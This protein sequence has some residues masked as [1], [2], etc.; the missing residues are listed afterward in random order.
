MAD[1]TNTN[2]D[3]FAEAIAAQGREPGQAGMPKPADIIAFE[4]GQTKPPPTQEPTP[5]PEK[6]QQ[7]G[8]IELPD[9]KVLDALAAKAD[10]GETLTDEEQIILATVAQ[11]NGSPAPTPTAE[12]DTDLAART[13]NIGGKTLTG[14]EVWE[15]ARERYNIGDLKIGPAGRAKMID[16]YIKSQNRTEFSRTLQQKSEKLAHQATAQTI[17]RLRLEQQAAQIKSQRETLARREEE[18][19]ARVAIK[20]SKDDLIDP[21]TGGID[22]DKLVQY[23]ESK[24]AQEDIIR[25]D[26]SKRGLDEQEKENRARMVQNTVNAFIEEHP[27]YRTEGDV[28]ETWVKFTEGKPISQDDELKVLE[29][30]NLLTESM[31][32]GISPE[33]IFALKK[34][35]RTLAVPELAQTTQVGENVPPLPEPGKVKSYGQLIRDFKKKVAANPSLLPGGGT[36]TRERVTTPVSTRLIRQDQ[37]TLGSERDTFLGELGYQSK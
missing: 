19:K 18:L 30:D 7:P 12:E 31:Q 37:A 11:I 1:E 13:F 24:R 35:Q 16:D 3:M 33:R 25:L 29:L 10:A 23:T 32:K 8:P 5:E 14:S 15:R 28:F 36:G 6:P 26:A 17:E 20:L 9:E 2:A 4:T 34:A 27:Q 22:P 21:V